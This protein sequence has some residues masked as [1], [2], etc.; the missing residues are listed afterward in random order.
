[1]LWTALVLHTCTLTAAP[2]GDSSSQ[3]CALVISQCFPLLQ[4]AD[5]GMSLSKW[6][7]VW[8]TDRKSSELW[9]VFFC[10]AASSP[11]M[12]S[13]TRIVWLGCESRSCHLLSQAVCSCGSA[14]FELKMVENQTESWEVLNC[15][16]E[17]LTTKQVLKILKIGNVEY[18][19]KW[20]HCSGQ[21]KSGA[22]AFYDISPPGSV[23][24]EDVL[25]LLNNA[26]PSLV[27][28]GWAEELSCSSA[29]SICGFGLVSVSLHCSLDEH[30][31]DLWA[32][33][34]PDFGQVCWFLCFIWVNPSKFILSE[35]LWNLSQSVTASRNS[36]TD[37]SGIK[38]LLFSPF[39][40]SCE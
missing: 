35:S 40:S 9:C 17:T 16:S 39:S 6:S 30:H 2:A 28:Q 24:W 36:V 31:W 33:I 15:R 8:L 23:R 13:K 3:C 26:K 14:K 29:V 7:R 12:G 11:R 34:F 21:M 19:E 27:V 5:V 37:L 4:R 22:L 25:T 20:L 38:I 32:K 1:M 18:R 10:S